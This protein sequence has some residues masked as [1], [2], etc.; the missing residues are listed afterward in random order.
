M[1]ICGMLVTASECVNDGLALNST[2]EADL[3]SNT[4]MHYS[5]YDTVVL[6]WEQRD[7]SPIKHVLHVIA[8]FKSLLFK[9]TSLRTLIMYSTVG[10]FW[11]QQLIRW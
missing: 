2:E 9:V 3:I 5:L 7:I 4:R 10:L 8:C 1:H 11:E 6:S